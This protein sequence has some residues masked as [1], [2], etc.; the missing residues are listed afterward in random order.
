MYVFGQIKWQ[1]IEEQ[2]TCILKESYLNDQCLISRARGDQA[3][4]S[5]VGSF[6][7][8]Y[9]SSNG[10]SSWPVNS[11]VPIQV[12]ASLGVSDSQVGA[13]CV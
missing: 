1:R 2:K 3:L 4:W 10:M 11:P 7:L 8:K 5:V 12:V 9:G 13:G 6:V